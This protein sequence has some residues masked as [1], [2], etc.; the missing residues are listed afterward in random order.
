MK[1]TLPSSN[2]Y[3]G[4]SLAASPTRATTSCIDID[5]SKSTPVATARCR[6]T[7]PGLTNGG[8]HIHAGRLAFSSDLRPR[9]LP[10]AD[11]FFIAVARPP[12]R[13]GAADVRA[14]V[15]RA[16]LELGLRIAARPCGWSVDGAG[17][18]PRVR[19]AAPFYE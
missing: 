18:H 9:G 6:F 10:T 15:V 8:T 17:R 4:L 2:R 5:E 16:A 3:V 19:G 1:Q 7:E 14:T 12:T 11:I 13:D